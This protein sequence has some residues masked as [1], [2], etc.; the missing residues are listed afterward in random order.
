LQQNRIPGVESQQLRF[1]F[2]DAGSVPKTHFGDIEQ[3]FPGSRCATLLLP[4]QHILTLSPE[5]E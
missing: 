1:R 3:P 4:Y 5:A 2:S